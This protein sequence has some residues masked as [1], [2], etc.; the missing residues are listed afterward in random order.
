M[1]QPAN[2]SEFTEAL[3]RLGKRVKSPGGL[4]FSQQVIDLL[5]LTHQDHVVEHSP[6]MGSTSLIAMGEKPRAYWALEQSTLIREYW[7]RCKD[8]NSDKLI[9]AAPWQTGF[10]DQCVTKVYGENFMLHLTEQQRNATLNEAHRIL[11]YGGLFGIHELALKRDDYEPALKNKIEKELALKFRISSKLYG[12]DQ[13]S[14]K[15]Y[16][17]DFKVTNLLRHPIVS[18][19]WKG[20][21]RDEGLARSMKIML[22]LNSDKQVKSR[23]KGLREVLN[24]YRDQLCALCI[25]G[26][27]H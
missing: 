5:S 26:V 11:K 20:V 12:P 8:L 17:H 4:K 7:K 9:D 14:D 10:E 1:Q 21:L 19:K 15:F 6:G 27:K 3:A 22:R 13:W 23:V 18:Y 2:H 24:K 25:I 16:Q